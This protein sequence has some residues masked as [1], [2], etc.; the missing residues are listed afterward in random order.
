MEDPLDDND[1]RIE[2]FSFKNSTTE[3]VHVRRNWNFLSILSDFYS[4]VAVPPKEF[5]FL[6]DI[7]YVW[8]E[9]FTI[10]TLRSDNNPGFAFTQN[11]G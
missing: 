9:T 1:S 4:S 5:F 8:L 6:S 7:G 3:I 10:P 2:S 11:E